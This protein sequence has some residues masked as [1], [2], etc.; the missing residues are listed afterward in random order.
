MFGAGGMFGGPGGGGAGD[1]R[2]QLT[3]SVNFQNLLNNTNLGAPVGN[4]T[5]Q[6]FG[7]PRASAGGFGGF[8]GGPG[9]GGGFGGASGNRKVELQVRFNF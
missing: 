4:L 8:G 6:L 9:G 1:S 3:L 7:L 5:S 2:Y